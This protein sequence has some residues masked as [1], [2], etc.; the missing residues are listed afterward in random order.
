MGMERRWGAPPWLLAVLLAGLSAGCVTRQDMLEQDRKLSDMIEQ[1]SRSVD[2]MR[3]ELEQMRNDAA[4]GRGTRGAPAPRTA[5]RPTSS[6]SKPGE[7]AALPADAA[8]PSGSAGAPPSVS[9]I[10]MTLSPDGQSRED[11]PVAE[12]V[13]TGA[14][15]TSAPAPGATAAVGAGLVGEAV[16][17]PPPPTAGPAVQR[18]APVAAD[19]EWRRE[20]AQE[21]AVA[22]ATGGAG[23]REYVDALQGLEQGD[24]KKALARLKA[25]SDQGG[26]LS[27]NAMYWEA[28]CLAARGSQRKAE[29]RLNQVV[30]RYPKSDKAPAALWAQA[31]LQQRSGDPAAAR[32]T[33]SRLIK[34]YPASAEATRAKKKL[35]ELD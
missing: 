26:S 12:T 33:L 15:P 29:A 31:E 23:Q 17:A 14:S 6:R 11:A 22:K 7:T 10:G 16:A 20:V 35:A 28:K 19:P 30:N 2:A 9:G 25:A 3:R 8:L 24:C 13:V 21:R 34:D 1:Q 32:G 27:D 18:A 5:P 4:R